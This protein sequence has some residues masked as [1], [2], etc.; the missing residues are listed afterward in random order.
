MELKARLHD[1][2]QTTEENQRKFN[3]NIRF[4]LLPQWTKDAATTI[5]G[6]SEIL[7]RG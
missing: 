4:R 7:L 1:S 2:F 6:Y 3:K 5:R